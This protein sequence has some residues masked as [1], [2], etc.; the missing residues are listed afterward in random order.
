MI[1]LK[2]AAIRGDIPADVQECIENFATFDAIESTNSYLLQ[3]P[4]P[5]PGMMNVAATTNQTSGRGRQGKTWD[6][7][8]GSGLCLSVA[9]TFAS[10][11]RDLPALT[12][13]LGLAAREALQELG[14]RDVQLK[15]PNDLMAGDG[16]LAGILTEV[17][18]QTLD[19]ATIVAGIGVNVDLG[20]D[21][22][23][24]SKKEWDRC[25]IDMK[26][27]CESPPSAGRIAAKL[28]TRFRTAFR[29]YGAQGF[30]PLAAHWAKYDWL[31]GRT[32][33]VR[34]ANNDVTGVASGVADDGALLLQTVDEGERRI[35]S[36]TI[37]NVDAQAAGQ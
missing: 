13:A 37:A 17:Q 33:Q 4:A 6:A 8:A 19:G 24:T 14:A 35:T 10:H 15:W 16:K 21:F 1:G 5:G 27:V 18:E 20:E 7:P 23:A 3:V 32:I 12:L 36:G 30:A 28:V 34:T 29:D 25:A 22:L 2:K 31:T 11:V 9:Y 26:H